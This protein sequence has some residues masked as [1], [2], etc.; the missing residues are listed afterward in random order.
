MKKQ[1]DTTSMENELKGGSAFFR[2]PAHQ[3]DDAEGKD[4]TT[5]PSPATD[6][7][8][9]AE[10]QNQ[11]RR[12]EEDNQ[13]LDHS[14]DSSI[15]Q[16]TNQLIGPVLSRPVAFYLPE[17]INQKIEEAV[18]YYQTKRRMKFDRSAIVSAILGDVQIWTTESLD[19][20]AAKVTEQLI[21]RTTNR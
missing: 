12:D 15:D 16:S 13:P 19:R 20:L 18:F 9:T 2:Q 1:L 3:T 5:L 7:S 21:N 6:L 17:S 4:A 14:V 8:F 10:N 11:P